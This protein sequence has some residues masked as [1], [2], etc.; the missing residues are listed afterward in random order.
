LLEQIVS[1][2]IQENF[3]TSSPHHQKKIKNRFKEMIMKKER[4]RLGEGKRKNSKEPTDH[5]K[6]IFYS[7]NLTI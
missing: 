1:Q 4:N 3:L 6:K 2:F 5:P 7:S